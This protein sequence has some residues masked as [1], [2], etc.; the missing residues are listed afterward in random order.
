MRHNPASVRDDERLSD[1]SDERDPDVFWAAVR[2]ADEPLRHRWFLPAVVAILI[3]SVPWYLPS[4][5]GDRLALGLPVWTWITIL[6]GLAL[7]MVTAFASLRL[8][9]DGGDVADGNEGEDREPGAGG[10]DG[11]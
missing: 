7:A 9:R 4:S 3:V 5:V 10:K 2:P 1:Y 11:A 8:W 6:C